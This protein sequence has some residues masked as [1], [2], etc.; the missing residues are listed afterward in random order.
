MCRS[1]AGVAVVAAALQFISVIEKPREKNEK[2][3]IKQM[4]PVLIKYII[5][6]KIH[7]NPGRVMFCMSLLNN[8]L[9]NDIHK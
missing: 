5:G 2:R 6:N 3:I 7:T 8:V 1:P 4:H 9:L